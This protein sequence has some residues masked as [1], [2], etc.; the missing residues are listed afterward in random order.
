MDVR[1]HERMF[2]GFVKFMAWNAVICLLILVF[3]ALVNA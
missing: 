1:G 3:L 2:D